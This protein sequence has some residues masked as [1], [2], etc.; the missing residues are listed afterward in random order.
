MTPVSRDMVEAASAADGKSTPASI[1]RNAGSAVVSSL[2]ASLV[3][4][5]DNRMDDALVAM[6]PGALSVIGFE[7]SAIPPWSGALP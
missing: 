7:S 4:D 2:S 5:G 6:G 3:Q 1:D